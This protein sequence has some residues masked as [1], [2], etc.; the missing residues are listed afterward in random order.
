MTKEKRKA[1]ASAPKTNADYIRGLND[2]DLRNFLC[3]LM[4]CEGCLFGTSSGCDLEGWLKR[5]KEE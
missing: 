1:Q 2:K 4:R 3:G 5:P